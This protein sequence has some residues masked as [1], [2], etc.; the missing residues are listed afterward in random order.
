MAILHALATCAFTLG[1]VVTCTSLPQSR[2]TPSCTAP[3]L[4]RPCPRPCT[5]PPPAV[6]VFV[7]HRLFELTNSL[8][9]AAVPHSNNALLAR[10]VLMMGGAG[11]ALWSTVAG[12]IALLAGA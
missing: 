3:A 10:N 6:Y 1:A 4:P 8:K 9:N 11:V 5:A 7:S 2:H 12:V